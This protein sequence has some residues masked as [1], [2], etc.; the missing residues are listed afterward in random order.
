M[1]K[2]NSRNALSLFI[3]TFEPREMLAADFL[4]VFIPEA[5]LD[6][7][8]NNQGHGQWGSTDEELIRLTSTEYGDGYSSPSGEDRASAREVSNAVNA[9]SESIEN[10]R[11]L[12]DLLWVFGQFVDH[13]ISIT[14]NATLSQ[15]MDIEV[16]TGDIYFDPFGTG[17]QV[18]SFNRSIYQGGDSPEDVRQQINQITSF[19]DGSV[20]Y[21]SS[22]ERMDA[23]REFSGGRLKTSAG[24]LLP[25][26]TE[27]L[28]NAGGT[29][30]ALFLAG[31]V[32][33]NENIA[34]IAMHTL[35]VREHNRI[36][37]EIESANSDLSD[38]EIFQVARAI[39]RAQLQSITYNE[40]LPALLG[41]DAIER[42]SG[43]DPNVNPN[44]AN[45]FSTAAY[46]FGHSMLS[47][48][49]LRL[50]AD[51]SEADEGNID[52]KNAFF[53]PA[54][55]SA[56]G[57]DS[58]LQGVAAQIGQEIDTQVVDDIRNFLFG[59]PGSG[60]FDLASLNIQRGRDHGL[61]SYN[62]TRI[63]LGLEPVTEFSEITSDT[64][65]LAKLQSVYES[66]DDVDLWIGGLAED[67]LPGTSMG[68]TFSTILVD[69]FTRLR[70]GDRFWYQNLFNGE[71]IQQIEE[72]TLADIIQRNSDVENLQRNVFFSA[73]AQP[74]PDHNELVVDLPR[75]NDPVRVVVRDGRVDIRT[76]DRLMERTLLLGDEQ[77]V[78]RGTG[79]DDHITVDLRDSTVGQLDRIV[80]NAGGG[81]DRVRIVG[82]HESFDGEL[83]INGQR[84]N[85][86]LN[87]D[88]VDVAITMFGGAGRD[89]LVGGRRADQMFGGGGDD[90]IM[91]G[92]GND[93]VC[94]GRGN[95]MMD[96]GDGT[97]QI[98]ELL[99]SDT[100]LDD[101]HME[102]ERRE[103]DR[104]FAM[105][106]ALLF[107]SLDQFEVNS[108]RF[109]GNVEVKRRG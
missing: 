44:I 72:T 49:L 8:G 57:I 9:Q 71:L 95:D 79:R 102:N 30:D 48:E 104:L 82:V 13:D 52:L 53:N 92:R 1:R 21:G 67:H 34:L 98:N 91:G 86:V 58:I 106:N 63:D 18:I 65:L 59:P 69:Q 38:E 20:I 11:S 19:I 23:L 41:N 28:D 55:I 85:D 7:T 35:W 66:V 103:I 12:T 15:S 40:F 4:N 109:H 73:D 62:Q 83:R 29:S 31:D 25:F 80:I 10:S 68:E 32:R 54:E 50:N 64:A 78:I 14:E 3:E 60:G 26:N 87:A 16:P 74:R 46:R 100:T 33:A 97:D 37:G 45:E 24:D 89:T 108:R 5:S 77:L 94:G 107:N 88:N 22:T 90:R 27:G 42:Y 81:H 101:R 75:T 84:G 51:G 70:D 105:E 47:S 6:G 61:A 43:Y 17:T 56:N 93:M 76:A 2:S 96:G 99:T 39:V 36:A